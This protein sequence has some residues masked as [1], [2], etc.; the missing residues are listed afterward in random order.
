MMT[1]NP[2]FA[3]GVSNVNAPLLSNLSRVERNRSLMRFGAMVFMAM[4]GGSTPC[5]AEMVDCLVAP[6]R[7]AD[8]A[9][10][11]SGVVRVM[12]VDR[13]DHVRKGQV[14]AMLDTSIEQSSLDIAQG[15]LTASAAIDSAQAQLDLATKRL[16]RSRLLLEKDNVAASRFEEVQND[17][18]TA[19]LKLA[20]LL[21]NRA[22][23]ALDV[24]RAQAV[25]ATRQVVSPFD[26]V[27]VE[28][29]VAPGESVDNKRVVTVSEIDPL[30][31]DIIAPAVAFDAVKLGQPIEV[32]LAHPGRTVT[33]VAS[34][35]DPYVDASSG[36]FR[37]RASL[38][39]PDFSIVPG[40]RCRADLPSVA[41]DGN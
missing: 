7:V 19:R 36:T 10:G 24:A 11:S 17:F 27:V 32:R 20:E 34:V 25:M 28:R 22:M 31:I 5:A 13:G 4:L 30:F 2:T 38:P 18:D 29:H 33:A 12:A 15:Q 26:A 23:R 39:N 14:L 1:E 41:S 40:F 37:V 9:F 21:E 3:K 8:L 6:H 16:Q 35:I